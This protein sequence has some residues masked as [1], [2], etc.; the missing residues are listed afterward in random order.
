MIME[1]RNIK[2]YEGQIIMQA[3]KVSS[4]KKFSQLLLAYKAAEEI[5]GPGDVCKTYLHC[6][7]MQLQA[8]RRRRWCCWF[9]NTAL[10][11]RGYR[12]LWDHFGPDI[13]DAQCQ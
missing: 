3:T 13:N 2:V 11:I 9:P 12:M 10:L 5:P 1:H 6:T 8:S 7:Q 4:A